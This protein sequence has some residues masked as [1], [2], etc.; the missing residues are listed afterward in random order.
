MV[1]SRYHFRTFSLSEV[2]WF[3]LYINWIY[4]EQMILLNDCL[5]GIS[6]CDLSYDDNCS[7]KLRT[8]SRQEEEDDVTIKYMH[9]IKHEK[10]TTLPKNAS[11][12]WRIYKILKSSEFWNPVRPSETALILDLME[13][14]PHCP[15]NASD[16]IYH[17]NRN[18]LFMLNHLFILF[19]LHFILFL[20]CSLV[21]FTGI[22]NR[23]SQ[24]ARHRLWCSDCTAFWTYS[25]W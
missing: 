25:G 23:V 12:E 16:L 9:I 11:N 13:S 8:V 20:Q 2:S 17:F 3:S 24:L 18:Y 1:K 6:L 19:R 14:L 21:C 15:S 4:E 10:Y 22:I 7:K 5:F